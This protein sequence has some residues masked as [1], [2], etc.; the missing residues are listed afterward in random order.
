[1]FGTFSVISAEETEPRFATRAERGQWLLLNKAFLPPDFDQ[2]TFDQLWQRWEEPAR[3]EAEKATPDERRKLLYA[4]YGLAE[5]ANDERHR[6]LQYVVSETGQWSMNCMACHQGTL[7]GQA[8]PGL[9][10]AQYNMQ[11]LYEDVRNTKLLAGKQLTHMDLGSAFVPLSTSRGTTNAVMFGVVLLNFRKPDL[12][13]DKSRPRPALTNHD[14]DAPAWW[15]Y[16]RKNSIYI[17]GFA[18][19][20]H[21]P[22]M[23]FLLVEQNGPAEFAKWERDFADVSVWLESLRAPKNPDPV[24]SVLAEK[25]KLIFNASCSKCH[26]TYGDDAKWPARMVPLDVV[27]TD[28]LRSRGLSV[29]QREHYAGSWFAH[30][31]KEPVATNPTGY[32]APPLD[33]IWASGPYFHNGSVPTLAAV[34]EPRLRP[35]VWKRNGDQRDPQLIGISYQSLAEVPATAKTGYEKREYYDTRQTG[36]SNAGHDFAR[37]LDKDQKLALLEYLKT[38]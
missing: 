34:L 29:K 26:G 15:H 10:N 1:V 4:R 6:P 17:D 5:R 35:V 7:A 18:P 8:I 11:S 27:G 37:A 2:E 9:A 21:R 13:V 36:K 32:V 14:H 38:L 22:L 25:G 24:D 28:P 3:G 19:K 31:G 30:A 16:H 33:G 23:Q 20:G 12:T